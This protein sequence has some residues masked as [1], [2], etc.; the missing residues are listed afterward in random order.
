MGEGERY[1]TERVL[2]LEGPDVLWMILDFG[3]APVRF[4]RCPGTGG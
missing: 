4:T 1:E 2:S 3:G